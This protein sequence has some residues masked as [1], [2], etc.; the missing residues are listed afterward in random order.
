MALRRRP[1]GPCGGAPAGE[2]AVRPRLCRATS[3]CQ[4]RAGAG[5]ANFL[6]VKAR[7]RVCTCDGREGWPLWRAQVTVLGM[8]MHSGV[9]ARAGH[10]LLLHFKARS[11]KQGTA[12]AS[13]IMFHAYT[14]IALMNFSQK[15][16]TLLFMHFSQFSGVCLCRMSSSPSSAGTIYVAGVCKDEAHINCCWLACVHWQAGCACQI[17]GL[18]RRP[19]RQRAL[20]PKG[21]A[22][23][24]CGA[25]G[26]LQSRYPRR[27][28]ARFWAEFLVRSV[29]RSSIRTASGWARERVGAGHEG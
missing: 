4:R 29:P 19:G 5:H 20:R 1:E 15:A 22:T 11:T 12:A 7:Q 3:A 25:D 8:L 18:D 13:F 23:A 17:T 14:Q 28:A 16:G 24:T 2:G 27:D 10:A 9:G 21:C 6:G 26:R